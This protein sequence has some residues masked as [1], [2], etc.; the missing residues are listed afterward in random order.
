[1]LS[2]MYELFSEH[3]KSKGE[4]ED[5]ISFMKSSLLNYSALFGDFTLP[6]PD[7]YYKLSVLLTGFNRPYEAE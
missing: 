1:M 3:H 7:S 6:V 4:V 5:S 2:Q